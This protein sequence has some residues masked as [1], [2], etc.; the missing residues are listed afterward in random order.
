MLVLLGLATA[1]LGFVIKKV[2]RDKV[3]SL[4]SLEKI[5]YANFRASS[6]GLQPRGAVTS[7]E[8]LAAP[9]ATEDEESQPLVA[10][11]S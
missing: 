9:V 11:G 1:S 2:F 7:L 10:D 6:P 4:R 3:L 5:V 8:M